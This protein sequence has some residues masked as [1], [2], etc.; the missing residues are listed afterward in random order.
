MNC[1]G[2]NVSGKFNTFNGPHEFKSNLSQHISQFQS[3]NAVYT[4][5][6]VAD[7]KGGFTGAV[8]PEE[9]HIQFSHSN[10]SI[11]G[12]LDVPLPERYQVAGHSS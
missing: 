1:D 9:F 3:S 7:L 4:Y 2:A 10:A 11:V 8:G 6:N 5:N 12:R